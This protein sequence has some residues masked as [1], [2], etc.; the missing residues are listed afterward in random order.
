VSL[1]LLVLA[2]S[3]IAVVLIF[4]FYFL[5][6]GSFRILKFVGFCTGCC[7]GSVEVVFRLFRF[8]SCSKSSWMR[9]LGIRFSA[10]SVDCVSGVEDGVFCFGGLGKGGV[11]VIRGGLH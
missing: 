3:S 11:L 9:G 6:W 1:C 10:A 4:C 7:G 5:C 8:W 2:P